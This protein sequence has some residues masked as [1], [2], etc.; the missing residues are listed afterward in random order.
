MSELHQAGCDKANMSI[1][2]KIYTRDSSFTVLQRISRKKAGYKDY[3]ELI[4]VFSISKVYPRFIIDC[5]WFS[6][7]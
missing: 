2:L 5:L 3:V 6:H 4:H 1:K 7:S